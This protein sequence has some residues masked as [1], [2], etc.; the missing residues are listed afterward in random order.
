MGSFS[1]GLTMTMRCVMLAP[2]S[3]ATPIVTTTGLRMYFFAM[4]STVGGIVALKEQ[5]K[6]ESWCIYIFL[7]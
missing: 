3:P 7:L 2:A 1:L 4:R 6:R 5:E